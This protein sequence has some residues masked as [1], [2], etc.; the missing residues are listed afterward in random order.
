MYA[1]M[2]LIFKKKVSGRPGFLPLRREI[3]FL[4]DPG[5]PQNTSKILSYHHKEHDCRLFVQNVYNLIHS[6]L[7]KIFKIYV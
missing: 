1:N 7:L 6:P 4:G 3:H 5:I 2:Q